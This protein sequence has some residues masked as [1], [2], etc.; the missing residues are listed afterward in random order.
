MDK[1]MLAVPYLPLALA[2]VFGIS[3]LLMQ[4]FVPRQQRRWLT[5]VAILEMSALSLVTILAFLS[6]AQIQAMPP[7]LQNLALANYQFLDGFALFFYL[8]LITASFVT[9]LVSAHYL[10]REN[11][12]RGEYY[13]LIFFALAGMMVMVS[14]QHLMTLFIGLEIMSMST[15]I[16]VGYQ[17]ES[18]RSNEGAFKYFMLGALASA[19]L[20]YGIALTY[21]VA[22]SLDMTAIQSFYQTHPIGPLG[23]MGLILILAGLGFKIG[24]V[25]FHTWTPDAYEGAPMPITGFMAT[26]IKAA[27]FALLIKILGGPFVMLRS[28]WVEL[29]VILSALTMITGNLLALVQ[30]NIKRMMAYSSIVHTGYLLMG[31]AALSIQP[32]SQI[33][34]ALLY[35]LFIYVISSLGV[36]VALTHLSGRGEK[37]QNIEDFSGLASEYPFTAAALGLFM[38]SF[39]GLPPLGGFF[40]KYFLF[41]EVIRLQDP[42]LQGL[43]VFAILNSILSIAYYLRII[44]TMYFKPVSSYWKQAESRPLS[45]SFLLFITGLITL[46]SGFAPFNLLGIIPGLTPLV[47]WL[48]AI[49]V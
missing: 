17:R 45:V 31:I 2:V 20:L 41:S 33:R 28:Y 22:G 5:Y 7:M 21:G 34:S 48:Q 37:I 27:A 49:I 44:T 24:A 40:A 16:L 43:A 11:L 29:V 42:L 36:F 12:A 47:N 25:P 4:V 19:L 23:S 3:Q 18:T 13:S 39:I 46:W 30:V 14:A 8:L 1:L 35:Y 6:R 38:F 32:D 9:I 15:Y 10:E 26:A